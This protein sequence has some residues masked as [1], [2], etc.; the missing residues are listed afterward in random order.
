V[1]S[2]GDQAVEQG[3]RKI[4][5][6]ELDNYFQD[7][8]QRLDQYWRYAVAALAGIVLFQVYRHHLIY[9]GS[10]VDTAMSLLTGLLGT[11]AYI[12]IEGIYTD[13]FEVSGRSEDRTQTH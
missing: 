9:L 8:D 13:Y 7:L 6:I 10:E 1:E 2:R 5:E 11:L 4:A 12:A 3:C